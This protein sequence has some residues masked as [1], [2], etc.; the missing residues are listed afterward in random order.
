MHV[1]F[2]FS[3][4]IALSCAAFRNNMSRM[5]R[6]VLA[7]VPHHITQRGTRRFEVFR[8][9]ADRETYLN[10]F[11]VSCRRFGLR[12]CAYCLMPNHVHVVGIPEREDVI[13]RTFHRTHGV[14]ATIFNS[15][16]GLTGHLWQAR[17]F[18]CAL[19][20][21]HFWAAV[22]Y[23]ERN[24]VRAGLV[25]RAEDYLWSSARAH[26]GL[27][28]NELLDGEST[29]NRVTDWKQWLRDDNDP[30]AE[31]F[32]RE[33]TVTGRPCGDDV[34]VAAAEQRYKK[35]ASNGHDRDRH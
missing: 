16:Y 30:K 21:A 4:G 25:R 8:D 26:C 3:A 17:P 5:G 6:V 9:E 29:A 23:V 18:S 35:R 27:E 13:W 14:Y 7:G 15:K 33:R 12:V 24:P 34:F 11:R 20:E 1:P 28:K 31:Q 2:S 19:D 32:I 10:I 22:R